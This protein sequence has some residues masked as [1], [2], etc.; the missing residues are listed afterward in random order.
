VERLARAGHEVLVL[1]RRPDAQQDWL[2]AGARTRAF[3]AEQGVSPGLLDTCEA[4]VH[5]AGEPVVRRLTEAHKARVLNSRARGTR[6]IA[7][8]ACAAGSVKT[9]VSASGIGFYG[10]HGAEPLTEASAPGEDF[11]ARVCVAWE[12]GLEPAERCG[13]RAVSLRIGAV[14]HP[15][16]GRLGAQLSS[17]RLG[18]GGAL[19]RGDQYVSWIH[20]EDL[21]GLMEHALFH[22]TLVGPVNATAPHPVTERDFS[23]ALGAVLHR[24]SWLHVPSFA[25]RLALGELAEVV[26]SGQRVLPERALESGFVFR[27]PDLV[28]ALADLLGRKPARDPLA[29]P[30]ARP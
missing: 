14:L 15:E 24:P 4:V 8:A 18:V 11:L 3:D 27:H 25:L 13:I 29:R 26:L 10:P 17:F 23:R 5:L 9:L 6:A 12:A 22:T 7:Q 21:L 16:G 19:G 2:P 1:T 28:P 30:A 20:R